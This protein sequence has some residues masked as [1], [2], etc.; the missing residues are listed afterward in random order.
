[1][2]EGGV[3]SSRTLVLPEEERSFSI[4]LPGIVGGSDISCE[5]QK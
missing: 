4:R 5:C 2:G 3:N 1:M